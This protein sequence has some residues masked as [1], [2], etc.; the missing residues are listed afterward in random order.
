MNEDV[1]SSEVDQVDKEL[2]DIDCSS[3]SLLGR[4]IG[5]CRGSKDLQVQPH[6]NHPRAPA[7]ESDTPSAPRFTLLL[8]MLPDRG[9]VND[10]AC[11][12]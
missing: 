12:T 9:R 3:E 1:L 8:L 2:D 6:E 11:R 4:L 10:S 7:E 5:S